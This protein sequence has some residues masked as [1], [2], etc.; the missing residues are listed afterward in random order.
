MGQQISSNEL[1]RRMEKVMLG[2]IRYT[3]MMMIVEQFGGPDQGDH[4]Q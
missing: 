4:H 2:M 1:T 3:E